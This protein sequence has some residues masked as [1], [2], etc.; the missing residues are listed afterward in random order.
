MDG[1]R[2]PTRPRHDRG[3]FVAGLLRYGVGKTFGRAASDDGA[4]RPSRQQRAAS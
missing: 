4:T 3:R 2:R 1:F